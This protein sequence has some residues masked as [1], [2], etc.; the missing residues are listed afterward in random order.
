MILLLPEINYFF[1]MLLSDDN[2]KL[3]LTLLLLLLFFCLGSFSNIL[4]VKNSCTFCASL[5]FKFFLILL[6]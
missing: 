5:P 1:L 3:L 6:I 4:N 2:Y